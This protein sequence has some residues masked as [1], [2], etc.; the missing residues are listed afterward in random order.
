MFIINI[1]NSLYYED[2]YFNLKDKKEIDRCIYDFE[3]I[4][5]GEDEIQFHIEGNKIGLKIEINNK[6]NPD[7]NIAAVKKELEDVCSRI[8]CNEAVR[9]SGKSVMK[10]MDDRK[11]SNK[12]YL[13]ISLSGGNTKEYLILMRGINCEMFPKEIE[14]I[15]E[16]IKNMGYYILKINKREKKYS[17]KIS[18]LKEAIKVSYKEK[19]GIEL[20]ELKEF[21]S[22]TTYDICF[23]ISEEK[24][25]KEFNLICNLS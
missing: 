22:K 5:I 2:K 16:D 18:N 25:P 17:Y 1:R 4:Y 8:F 20:T 6:L 12:I 3:F 7:I 19:Y 15:C 24:I 14:K 11:K 13:H 23:A 10:I 21:Y 9:K